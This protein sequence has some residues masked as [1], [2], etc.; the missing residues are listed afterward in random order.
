MS[1]AD[2]PEQK[3]R[4]LQSKLKVFHDWP[5]EYLFK[6]IVPQE[7]LG[8]LEA[9]FEGHDFRTRSSKHGRWVS[10]TCARTMDSSEAVIE[11]YRAVDRIEGAYSL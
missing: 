7:K 8:E 2:E 10:L 4:T 5:T 3:F 6:F 11:V 1:R 9:I